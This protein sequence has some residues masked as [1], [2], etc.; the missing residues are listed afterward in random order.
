[1]CAEVIAAKK[2]KIEPM[3]KI[4]ITIYVLLLS[5]SVLILATS[6]IRPYAY[7]ILVSIMAVIVFL[8]IMTF[9]HD[10][11][12]ALIILPQVI[13]LGITVIWG[14]TLKYFMYIG[15]TDVM[16][17]AWYAETLLINGQITEVFELY[18]AF[19]LWHILA[20]TLHM[21]SGMN[22]DII[23]IMFIANGIIFAM[24]PIAI[25]LVAMKLSENRKISLLSALILILTPVVL[26]YGMYAIA[27]SV[28][29]FFLIVLILMLLEQKNKSKFLLA[30]YFT[31]AIVAFH[32]VSILFVLVL[33]VLLYV[34]QKV[35]SWKIDRPIISVKYLLIAVIILIAYWWTLARDLIDAVLHNVQMEAPSGVV[36]KAVINAPLNELFNYLQFSPYLFF[37]ILGALLVLGSKKFSRE[38][39]VFA[40]AALVLIPITFPGPMLLINKLSVNFNL[41]RFDEY[42]FLFMGIVAATG[43]TTLY[44]KPG[45]LLKTTCIFLFAAMV[46]LSVS[47]DFVASDNPLVKRPFYTSY[48][49]ENEVTAFENILGTAKASPG[50]VFS[51]YVMGRYLQFSPYD[52]TYSP[53]RIY[54]EVYGPDQ[55][56]LW[57][58]DQDLYL[59]RD[60]ELE[61]RDL[62]FY[63][64]LSPNYTHS[65]NGN[66]FDYFE[67]PILYDDL[68]DD[69]R[70]YDSRAVRGYN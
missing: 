51:D 22:V 36:T 4:L 57:N 31:L 7:Y 32:T 13:L 49:T 56:F 45:K 62:K 20:S 50:Y 19:P 16:G 55:K 58:S 10:D 29:A 34:I 26:I 37:I 9:R 54:G 70:V 53:F 69:N 68:A 61:K 17:H 59:I 8:E 15:R 11:R 1:M 23:R 25:Y 63:N 39:K 66:N 18:Q 46:L 40:I 42:T 21:I 64:A 60:Q 33:F 48:L 3:F 27:R 30:I 44:S 5:L 14:V 67:D 6:E 38:M 35:L 28:T 12:S 47:N 2:E 43:L 41:E 52:A 65:V 24:L